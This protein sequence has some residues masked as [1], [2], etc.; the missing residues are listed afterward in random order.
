[1]LRSSGWGRI[2]VAGL[3]L[4]AMSAAVGTGRSESVSVY[5]G[6][7][8]EPGKSQ[9]IYR[10]DFDTETGKATLKGLAAEAVNPS[11]LALH[12]TGK[13]L[14]AVGE[15]SM[16][17]GKRGGGVSAF[18]VDPATGG[19]SPLNQ[20]SSKGPGPCHVAV[21]PAG[22]LVFVAN[23]GGGSVAALPVGSDGTLGEATGFVQHSGSSVNPRRQEGPHAHGV[24]LDGSGTLLAVPDLGL[25]KILLYRF[26]ANGA[27]K[28]SHPDHADVAP[29]SG[30][31][32]LAWHPD[33]KHAYVINEMASTVTA[34][35]YDREKGSLATTQTVTTLPEGYHGD[36]STAEVVVHP[37]GKWL[38]GSNRGHDSLA[39]FA[40]DGATGRLRPAGHVATGGKTPRNFA[41]DPTGRFLLA[42]NQGSDS[43]V[44]F[45]I[46]PET[47]M[48]KPTG[49][50]VAV[51][52]PV[53]VVFGGKGR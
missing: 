49:D 41:I 22:K 28:A 18:A 45:R 27:L 15:V 30:P 11:F 36:S 42:A 17:E 14:Y 44:V 12:P 31:R 32:H 20:Q 48:P 26:E 35:D 51:G 24:H 3:W 13:F 52:A 46:D 25:D 50:S 21:D 6:T 40:I 19:L 9:G 16:F 7:Y 53:C 23:Y 4:A 37:N 43:I 29:G 38:Y 8:T 1:M 5:V 33:G 39:V 10:L 47:G 2:R 34:L